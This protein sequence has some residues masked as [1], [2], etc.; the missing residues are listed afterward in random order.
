MQRKEQEGWDNNL[1]K[2]LHYQKKCAWNQTL[3]LTDSSSFVLLLTLDSPAPKQ[4]NS[5]YIGTL[6]QKNVYDTAV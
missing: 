1:L 2:Q 3:S 5:V 6:T 4:L